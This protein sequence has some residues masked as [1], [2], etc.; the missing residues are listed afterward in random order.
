VL[1]DLPNH[2]WSLFTRGVINMELRNYEE[3]RGDP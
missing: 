1:Q 3:A 2:D